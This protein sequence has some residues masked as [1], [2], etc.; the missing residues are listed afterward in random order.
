[1]A[2]TY[3]VS[4]H[5]GWRRVSVRDATEAEEAAGRGMA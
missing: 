3:V 5:R 2:V 4:S 1:M